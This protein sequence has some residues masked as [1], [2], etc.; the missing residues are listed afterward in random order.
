[1]KRI[2]SRH[3]RYSMVLKTRSHLLEQGL[4]SPI[5]SY[6]SCLCTP[7][8]FLFSSSPMHPPTPPHTHPSL[9]ISM[10]HKAL[11]FARGALLRQRGLPWAR[12][13]LSR[14]APASRLLAAQKS[15]SQICSV[16]RIS[17][18]KAPHA[19]THARTHMNTHARTHARTG[20]RATHARLRIR[21][22]LHHVRP[23]PLQ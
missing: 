11:Q 1:M 5:L 18:L 8:L 4:F 14:A 23:H 2:V 6:P 10:Q 13:R 17:R 3:S 20:N 16:A 12:C 9:A 15:G 21:L 19:R 22:R 7:C